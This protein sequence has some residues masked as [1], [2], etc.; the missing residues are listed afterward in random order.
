MAKSRARAKN[1]AGR[2]AMFSGP[3]K[4]RT[5]ILTDFASDKARADAKALSITIGFRVSTSDAIE[6]AVRSYRPQVHR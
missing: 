1:P 5:I 3:K 4:P 2:P 6:T